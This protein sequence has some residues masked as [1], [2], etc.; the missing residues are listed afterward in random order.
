[1]EKS[2]ELNPG[3]EVIALD[4]VEWYRE[5]R[6]VAPKDAD[7]VLFDSYVWRENGMVIEDNCSLRRFER[8]VASWSAGIAVVSNYFE[9]NNESDEDFEDELDDED[10]VDDNDDD[11]DE[12]DEDE[13]DLPDDEDDI[14]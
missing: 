7:R 9:V 8:S 4:D 13:D 14:E 2:L 3:E 5:Y 1:M 12:F 6:A 10:L 11:Y